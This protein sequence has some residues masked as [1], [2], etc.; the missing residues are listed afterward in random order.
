M[1]VILLKDVAKIGRRFDVVNVPDGFALNKLIPKGLAESATGENLKRLQ[2]ISAKLEKD[3]TS[4]AV[5]FKEAV[6][7]LKEVQVPVEVEA[8]PEG[9]MFQA[10]KVEAIV[11]AVTKATGVTLHS[12]QIVIESPIKSLG[13]HNV[14]LVSGDTHGTLV[15][16]LIAKSK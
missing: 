9:R 1:K 2:N 15:L 11:S 13:E 14:A 3:R 10:L 7:T 12:E 6:S 8:N 5:S 16:N 4:E